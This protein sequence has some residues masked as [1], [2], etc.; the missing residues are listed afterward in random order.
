MGMEPAIS[1]VPVVDPVRVSDLFPA[2]VTVKLLVNFSSPV[3]D[4]SRIAPPVRP[5]RLI[6]RSLVSLAAPL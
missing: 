4:W 5:A 6:T 1:P 3:P 2:P